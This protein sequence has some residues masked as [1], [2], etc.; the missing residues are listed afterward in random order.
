MSD[1]GSDLD[2]DTGDRLAPR[3]NEGKRRRPG[4]GVHDPGGTAL[5]SCA[6]GGVGE[7]SINAAVSETGNIKVED[8]GAS[9]LR[10]GVGSEV[11]T[12]SARR[13]LVQIHCE[14]GKVF[15]REGEGVRADAASKIRDG[16]RPGITV[17]AGPALGHDLAGCLF[18]SVTRKEE[19]ACVFAEFCAGSSAQI[20]LGEDG[21]R[22]FLFNAALA[23]GLTRCE[24]VAG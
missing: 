11:E 19:R 7:K 18:E 2:A 15:F 12:G 3:Q 8:V 16:C 4:L 22:E 9:N 20:K 1:A 23:Q 6:P 14:H 21:V 24:R 17:A 5:C 10:C 13:V